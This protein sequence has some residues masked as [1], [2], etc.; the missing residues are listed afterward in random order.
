M[1]R[2][3]RIVTHD[4]KRFIVRITGESDSFITGIEVDAHGDEVVPPGH[5]NRMRIVARDAIR[6]LTPMRMNTTYATLE[7]AR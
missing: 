4:G 5:H 1:I 3:A 7:I 2:Y 6:K